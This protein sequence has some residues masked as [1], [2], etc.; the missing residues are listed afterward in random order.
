MKVDRMVLAEA[1]GLHQTA[2]REAY[3]R[4]LRAR[5]D[6]EAAKDEHESA[7]AAEARFKEYVEGVKP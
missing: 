3:R 6:L 1:L 2:V 5:S 4:Y 7:L